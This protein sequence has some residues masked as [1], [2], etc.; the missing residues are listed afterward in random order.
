MEE[1]FSPKEQAEGS[2]P[3]TNIYIRVAQRKEHLV[4]DQ[5]MQ[6][7]ILSRIYVSVAQWTRARRYERRLV[8]GSSPV[9]DIYGFVV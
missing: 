3:F 6:V 4:P 8:A 5:K 1:R 9:G 2:N 7:Q